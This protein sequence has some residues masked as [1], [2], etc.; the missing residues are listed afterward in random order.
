[1]TIK[2]RNASKCREFEIAFATIIGGAGIAGAVIFWGL[3]L[4][5]EFIVYLGS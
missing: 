2:E 4:Y 3:P 5:F 1:M